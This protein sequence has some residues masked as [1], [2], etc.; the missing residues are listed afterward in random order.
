MN[1]TAAVLAGAAVAAAVAVPTLRRWPGPWA[2]NH[3]GRR[4]PVSL[5]AAVAGGVLAGAVVGWAVEGRLPR[6]G[7]GMLLAALFVFGVGLVDD[8]LPGG[9]RGLRG[10][11]RAL[12]GGRVSTGVLKLVVTVAA[13]AVSVAL[14]PGRGAWARIAGVLL[15]AGAANLWNGL[16]VAPGR[17]LKAFLPV[18]VALLATGTWPLLPTLPAALGAGIVALGPDVREHAML[19]DG[20]SNLL[21]FVLGQALYLA[22]PD[23]AVV[24]GAIGAVGLN[25]LAETVTL[26]AMILGA[27]PLRWLD[28]LGRIPADPNAA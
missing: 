27:R 1:R 7:P 25:V 16:D 10:H 22:L 13:A 24:L 26:S 18:G 20:G 5:G 21:G 23:W 11:V 2:R 8:A 17:A 12:A 3:R 4:L 28:G 9:A 19:G 6:S 14:V 15:V